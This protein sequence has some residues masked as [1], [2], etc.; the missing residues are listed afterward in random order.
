MRRILFKD[1]KEGIDFR[2]IE[3]RELCRYLRVL[4]M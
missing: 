3:W 4:N 1:G 2:D